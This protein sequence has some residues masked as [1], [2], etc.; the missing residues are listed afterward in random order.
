[1]LNGT[2]VEELRAA[3]YEA[4]DEEI[5]RDLRKVKAARGDVV[6]YSIN[7]RGERISA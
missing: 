4:E 5:R 6:A 7:S 2:T 1:M 3:A